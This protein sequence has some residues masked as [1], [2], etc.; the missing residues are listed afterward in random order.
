MKNNYHK[1]II[2]GWLILVWLLGVTSTVLAQ[3]V[4]PVYWQRTLDRTI[5]PIEFRSELV[6]SL[7]MARTT[8]GGCVVV[9]QSAFTGKPFITKLGPGGNVLWTTSLATFGTP[10]S[11]QTTTTG[12]FLIVSNSDSNPANIILT[13]IG[14]DGA[15]LLNQY[16]PLPVDNN[17]QRTVRDL[18]PSPDGGFL[19]A[20]Y[21]STLNTPRVRL[22]VLLVK[23]DKDLTLKWAKRYAGSESTFLF[24]ANRAAD[25]GYVINS[26]TNSPD[27]TG[28]LNPNYNL[29]YN[30]KVDEEGNVMWQRMGNEQSLFRDFVPTATGYY[31]IGMST[32]S[33]LSVMK[34]DQKMN[35]TRLARLS[36]SNLTDNQERIAVRATPD[37]GCIVVDNYINS[38]N[39]SRD[40]RITKYNQNLEIDWQ[41][42][43]GGLGDDEARIVN[44]NDD[45]TYF[46]AGSTNSEGLFGRV[47]GS[48]LATIW[49]R[50]QASSLL[51][52]QPTYNCATGVITFNTSGGDGSP[53]TYFAPGISR[54]SVTS[55]TG[56]V[57]QGLRNDP[58]PILIQAT[59]RG[60]TVSYVFDL[61]KYLETSCG[62]D[63]QPTDGKQ[64]ILLAPTFNCTSGAITFNTSGGD[65][66]PVEFMAIGITGWTTNPNQYV[67][68]ES[69][70][71][72]DVKPFTLMARQNGQVVSYTWDLKAACGRARIGAEEVRAKLQVH[73]LGNPVEGEIAEIDIVNA[74][75]QNV[76][77]NL[78]DLQGK[79]LFHHSIPEAGE[80]E[81]LRIPIRGASGLLLLDVS[82][83]TDRQQLKLLKR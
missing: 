72:N 77:I 82:T 50:K 40:Y 57:E 32:L 53:I 22:D 20:G 27:I 52:T 69:R 30:F 70:T 38:N 80:S 47:E 25:G 24:K 14:A 23:L 51:L 67:D 37:G 74:L 73:V 29:I 79:P 59:Q 76:Q 13:K 45:G 49:V 3:S 8:D 2:A 83:A 58:K 78:L 4:P 44:V 5:L 46:I 26:T 10:Y 12:D 21:E 16:L 81:R 64:L 34:F 36:D 41:E 66:S 11:V 33:G 28:N 18:I 17:L 54:T 48:K 1:R 61:R 65:G 39:G 60:Q 43:G 42:K 68:K 55:N 15:L 7:S 35:M 31:A 62:T 56:I 6:L 19:I 71:A 75:G 63:Q 9:S